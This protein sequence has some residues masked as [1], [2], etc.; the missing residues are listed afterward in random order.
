MVIATRQKKTQPLEIAGFTLIELLVVISIIAVLISIL[1]PALGRARSLA[2][3]T[4]CQTQL[5]QWGLAFEIYAQENDNLYPHIDSQDRGS[6]E[7]DNFGWVDMIP[8]MMGEKPFYDYPRGRRPGVGSVF[9]CPAAQLAPLDCYTYKPIRNGFF[10]YAM[11][12]CLELDENCWPP[13]DQP[14]GNNMPSFLKTTRI[15]NSM[16]VILLFDQL[17]DPRLGY[18]G[19]E[20][21][22]NAGKYCGS[23]PKA[24]SARHARSGEKIGGSLLY[25]DTHVEWK[26]TVWKEDWPADLE[27]PPRNDYNW[28]PY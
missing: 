21:Y 10:S 11:N 23:Y 16:R 7:A 14:G 1:L 17:L 25:C 6:G 24:F 27:V 28:Y 8:P 26:S 4:V 5:R 19:Q 20:K 22:R 18:D 15:K 12:S 2:K 13:Y 9:Q 3:Q